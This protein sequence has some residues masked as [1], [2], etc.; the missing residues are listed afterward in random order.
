MYIQGLITRNFTELANAVQIAHRSSNG[1][2][3]DEELYKHRQRHTMFLAKIKFFKKQ[4]TLSFSAR[5]DRIQ[6]SEP[7]HSTFQVE[8]LVGSNTIQLLYI[9]VGLVK[10]ARIKR[11][12]SDGVHI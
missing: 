5:Y 8:P 3:A 4:S 12:L 2:T 11:V 1:T 10:H 7:D 6:I 9:H